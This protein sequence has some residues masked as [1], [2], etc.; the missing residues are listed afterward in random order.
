M[1][2]LEFIFGDIISIH[3]EIGV[4]KTIL[5]EYFLVLHVTF[6]VGATIKFRLSLSL[7]LGLSNLID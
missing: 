6:M 3:E 2:E 7:T 1:L 4:R 5:S